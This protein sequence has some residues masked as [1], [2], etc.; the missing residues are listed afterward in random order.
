MFKGALFWGLHQ[1]QLANPHDNWNN[2]ITTN[3]K[4]L[5][6]NALNVT[7]GQ[8]NT[9]SDFRGPMTSVNGVTQGAALDVLVAVWAV[10]S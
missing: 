5:W 10:T 8:C 7:N 1:L 3:A 6:N 9:G 2:F 4:A